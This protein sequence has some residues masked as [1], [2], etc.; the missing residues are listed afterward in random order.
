MVASGG[1]A[2]D[3]VA[4]RKSNGKD[5]NLFF[6][7]CG[8]TAMA[9]DDYLNQVNKYGH[10]GLNGANTVKGY[11][12]VKRMVSPEPVA[13]Y[14]ND[15]IAA[16][17]QTVIPKQLDDYNKNIFPANLVSAKKAPINRPGG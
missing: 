17:P 9:D 1:C 4:Y 7:A 6:K 5:Q 13:V 15:D 16:L 10:Y 3:M 12:P 8:A 2:D 11:T 14:T